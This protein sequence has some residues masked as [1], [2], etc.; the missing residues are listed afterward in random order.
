[1]SFFI[2]I[3]RCVEKTVVNPK[4]TSAA[5]EENPV[6]LSNNNAEMDSDQEDDPGKMLN[7]W[8]GQ[9]QKV[10]SFLRVVDYE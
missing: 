5:V 10:S 7:V 6:Q 9:L 8:L 4:M 2:G 3:Y 1:M